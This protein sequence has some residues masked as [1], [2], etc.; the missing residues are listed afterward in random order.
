[1]QDVGYGSSTGVP[2]KR[3]SP[4]VQTYSLGL[5]YAFTTNDVLTASYVGNRGTHMLTDNVNRAQV[6]PALVV[7]GNNLANMV[8]NPFYGVIKPGQSGCGLDAKTISQGHLLSPFPQ[9]CGLS[10][11]QAPEGDSFY[12]ALQVDFNHRF[13]QGLNVLVSYTYSKFIDDTGGTAD[14]AYVGDSSWGYRNSYNLK[15]DKSVDGSNLPQALV[16][17]YIYELPVG[18]KGKFLSNIN[19]PADAVIGGWQLSGIN[20]IKAGFPLSVTGG[21]NTNMWGGG[22]H[23]QQIASPSLSNRSIHEW[24]NTAAFTAPQPYSYG[25]TA[26]YLSYL[27]APGYNDWDLSMQKFFDMPEKMKLQ[28]RADFFNFPNHANFN[29]PDTGITDGNY[30]KIT[31]TAD[32]RQI[33]FAMKVLW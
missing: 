9:Y 33:L 30:G 3:H 21:G 1:M 29:A 10:E 22:Q 28:F 8:P 23:S 12:N 31:N 4:Y 13:S 18:R 15:M 14:W 24:F 7:P 27:H 19:R 2:S 26:R 6:N 11:S 20:S 32:A 16:V 5:Q 17:N 25:N